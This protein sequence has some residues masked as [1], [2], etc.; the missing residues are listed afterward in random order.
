MVKK[1]NFNLII[2]VYIYKYNVSFD[3]GNK[4]YFS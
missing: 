1:S 3:I 4:L 2:Y